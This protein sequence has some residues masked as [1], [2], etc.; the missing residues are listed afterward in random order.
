MQTMQPKTA[1]ASSKIRRGYAGGDY[2]QLS[3]AAGFE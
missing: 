2:L 3:T 1:R